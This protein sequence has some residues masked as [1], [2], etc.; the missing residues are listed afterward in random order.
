[1]HT[2]VTLE[3]K[4]DKYATSLGKV[5]INLQSL[6]FL[7]R[8]FLLEAEGTHSEV[9]YQELRVGDR[10]P[11]NAFTNWDSLK[12]LIEKYNRRIEEDDP[13]LR[14]SDCVVEIRDALAHGRVSAFS[15]SGPR[16]VLKFGK[17]ENGQV[18]VIFAAQMDTAWFREQIRLI[19]NQLKKV[20]TAGEQL[21]MNA[22]YKS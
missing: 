5:V 4:L 3:N 17:P 11:E 2:E 8:V 10:V 7:L 20:V 12:D 13:S 15:P 14:V 18:D 22:F 16:H 1:M 21:G 6:E 9:D 19:Y